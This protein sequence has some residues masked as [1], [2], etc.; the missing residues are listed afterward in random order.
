MDLADKQWEILQP[1]IP[2]LPRCEDRDC[3]VGEV[4]TRTPQHDQAPGEC[5]SRA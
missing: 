2:E 5:S 1:L 4:T 3:G